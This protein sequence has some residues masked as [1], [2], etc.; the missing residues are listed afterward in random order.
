M[1]LIERIRNNAKAAIQKRTFH[2]E[3]DGGKQ[4]FR[5]PQRV[6][7][8]TLAQTRNQGLDEA[9]FTNWVFNDETLEFVRFNL[10][11]C[12][13]TFC[14]LKCSK[15]KNVIDRFVYICDHCDCISAETVDR[16]PDTK[17]FEQRV[18]G[19]ISRN[20][21]F[22]I[23]RSQHL[24]TEYKLLLCNH[25]LRFIA[26]RDFLSCP[27][28]AARTYPSQTTAWPLCR[29]KCTQNHAVCQPCGS[30]SCLICRPTYSLSV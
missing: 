16:T 15:R 20:S 3:F 6:L 10:C 7:K 27:R 26:L 9:N 25:F 28:R 12:N 17:L 14:T 4:A 8:T 13:E 1:D 23:A 2:Q 29:C 19:F 18:F 21:R 11:N 30:S 5:S 22:A 24:L